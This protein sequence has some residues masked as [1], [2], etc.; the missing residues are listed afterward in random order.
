MVLRTLGRWGVWVLVV[1]LFVLIS[2]TFPVL[3]V[4]VAVIGGLAALVHLIS[5]RRSPTLDPELE[6]GKHERLL[7]DVPPGPPGQ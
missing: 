6:R 1:V 5:S 3:A 7:R 2:R 4:L